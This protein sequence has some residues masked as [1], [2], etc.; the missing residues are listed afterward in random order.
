MADKVRQPTADECRAQAEIRTDGE[1]VGYACWYPSTGGYVGKAVI[2]PD[3]G[4]V[5]V[6]VWHDGE[7]PFD[8][9][10]QECRTPREPVV[11]HHCEGQQF[12][13]FGQLISKVMG[14]VDG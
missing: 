12:V 14:E 13:Q 10:C 7:F 4:C 6:Y 1:L 5:N 2:V 3:K 9:K 11:L 8:G